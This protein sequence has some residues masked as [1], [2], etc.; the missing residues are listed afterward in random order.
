MY[1]VSLDPEYVKFGIQN[2]LSDDVPASAFTV[3]QNNIVVHDM[4][5]CLYHQNQL[6][7]LN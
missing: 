1:P 7:R 2:I 4:S 3:R 5:V 6:I